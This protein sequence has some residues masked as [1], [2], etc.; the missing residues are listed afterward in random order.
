MCNLWNVVGINVPSQHTFFFPTTRETLCLDLLGKTVF[1]QL[2][3]VKIWVKD[4]HRCIWK[5]G[6][7]EDICIW[8]TESKKKMEKLHNAEY[9]NTKSLS[10]LQ[11]QWY[12]EDRDAWIMWYIWGRREQDTRFLW[13]NLKERNH[14][15][16]PWCILEDNITMYFQKQDGM[17][18]SRFMFFRIRTSAGILWTQYLWVTKTAENSLSN[19]R[20]IQTPDHKEYILDHYQWEFWCEHENQKGRATCYAKNHLQGPAWAAV[21]PVQQDMDYH[22]LDFNTWQ[23]LK[24]Y[25]LLMTETLRQ[26]VHHEWM[27]HP[28]H[29]WIFGRHT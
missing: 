19:G 16:Y 22:L 15:Q 23:H 25:F 29:I 26:A 17:A 13:R 8:E 7:Q 12:K 24:A 4:K 14:L 28:L 27:Q 6:A 21:V 11:G 5:Q 9:H 1:P 3:E 10:K 2:E 18:Q 20:T